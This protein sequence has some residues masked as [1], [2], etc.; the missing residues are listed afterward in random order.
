MLT[1]KD[2]NSVFV[3][4]AFLKVDKDGNKRLSIDEFKEV[5][6]DVDSKLRSYPA[7]AQVASQQGHYLGEH[8][9]QLASHSGGDHDK[10]LGLAPFH[11]RHLG[12]FSYVGD[13]KAVLKVPI[14]GSLSGWWVM[15]LWRASYL[16]ECVGWR[17]RCLVAF[18]WIKT[19]V[20]GRDTSR[21]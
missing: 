13:D 20:S 18:D 19:K 4:R 17:T 9:T 3:F 1:K 12:S 21:I 7:T 10:S 16:N 2:C 14:F 15:W 11:Y 8:F 5:L 6:K